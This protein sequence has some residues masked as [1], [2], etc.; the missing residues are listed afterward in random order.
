[1]QDQLDAFWIIRESN[2]LGNEFDQ[3]DFQ[4]DPVASLHREFTQELRWDDV[5]SD[6]PW[7]LGEG[8]R[9]SYTKMEVAQNLLAPR[10]D[11]QMLSRHP[12]YSNAV[13]VRD[14]FRCFPHD[15]G[16]ESL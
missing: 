9:S 11:Q 5:L 3:Y 13:L 8:I 1:M 4:Q 12:V 16:F 15:D 7:Q 14:H 10:V 6:L 2:C